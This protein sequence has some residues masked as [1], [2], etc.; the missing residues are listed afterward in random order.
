MNI[1]FLN[2]ITHGYGVENIVLSVLK[3]MNRY[4]QINK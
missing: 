3:Y 2:A 1:G 4:T